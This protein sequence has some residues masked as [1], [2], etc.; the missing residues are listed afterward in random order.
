[1]NSSVLF[2][3]C[4]NFNILLHLYR[5]NFVNVINQGK[6]APFLQISNFHVILFKVPLIYNIVLLSDVQHG[7]SVFL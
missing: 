4:Q 1:M 6:Y 7:D 5:T 3:F 2:K